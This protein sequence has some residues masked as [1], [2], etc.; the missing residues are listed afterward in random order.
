MDI[1]LLVI[2]RFTFMTN[3]ESKHFGGGLKPKP[4]KPRPKRPKPQD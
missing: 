4:K 2:L 3:G 1:F